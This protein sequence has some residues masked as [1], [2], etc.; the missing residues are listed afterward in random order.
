[1]T[2]N[3]HLPLLLP[4]KRIYSIEPVYNN[5]PWDPK[6]V[7]VVDRWSLVLGFSIKIAIKFGLAGQRLAVVGWWSL[8]SG[9][10]VLN[11]EIESFNREQV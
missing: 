5:H 10:F 7:A 4:P 3:I 8:F 6:I 9:N 1:V 11:I 2:L